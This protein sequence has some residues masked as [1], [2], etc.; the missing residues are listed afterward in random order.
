MSSR[1]EVQCAHT[2]HA[3]QS[4]DTHVY[5][6][7]GNNKC[8]NVYQDTLR[9]GATHSQT[10]NPAHGALHM[11]IRPSAHWNVPHPK[12]DNVMAFAT[13]SQWPIRVIIVVPQVALTH[14]E[15]AASMLTLSGQ[16]RSA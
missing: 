6:H 10:M 4:S 9:C 11:Y 8:H 1:E 14:V 12:M 13:H 3:Q 16:H 7:I 5:T 2:N 15:D